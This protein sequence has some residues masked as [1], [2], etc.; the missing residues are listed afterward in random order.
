MEKSYKNLEELKKEWEAY[1]VHING[2]GELIAIH[3]GKEYKIGQANFFAEDG[4]KSK[5]KRNRERERQ[6]N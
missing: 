2:K 3:E 6:K 5:F 1:G 4:K